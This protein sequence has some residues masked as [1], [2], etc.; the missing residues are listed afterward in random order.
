MQLRGI[1]ENRVDRFTRNLRLTL[2]PV[3]TK[4]PARRTGVVHQDVLPE[5]RPKPRKVLLG[6][7]QVKIVHIDNQQGLLGGVPKDAGL[8]VDLDETRGF[9]VLGTILLPVRPSIGVAV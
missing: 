8:A 1:A 5:V 6:G 7:G 4:K 9:D 3:T 2:L